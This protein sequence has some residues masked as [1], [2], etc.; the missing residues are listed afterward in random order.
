MSDTIQIPPAIAALTEE[1][2]AIRRDIHAHPEI[3]FEEV[4]TAGIV[5]AKLRSLGIEVH[6][7]VGKTGVVGVLTAG[8]GGNRR[9]GLRADMDALPLDEETGLEF[10]ST[11]PGK[12]H[13]CGH[14]VHTTILLGAAQYLAESRNFDGTVVFVFQPAEEGLGGARAMLADG[15]FERFPVDEIFG[16]H[17][18]SFQPHGFLHVSP[19]TSMAGADFFDI[20]IKGRGGHAAAPENSRDPLLAAAALTQALQQIISRNVAANDAAVVSVTELHAGSAYNIIADRAQLRG[21]VRALSDKV[22][23]AIGERIRAIAAGIALSHDVEIEVK[24]RDVF[25]TLTNSDEQLEAIAE[26]GRTVLGEANVSTEPRR[27]L[28]SEDFADFLKVVPGA[29]F[30]V[31]HHGTV[32]LHNPK[33]VV[34]EGIIPVGVTLF[35]RLVEARLPVVAR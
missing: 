23:A 6:E 27:V 13:G 31:G 34:D 32:P 11:I 22:R 19:G 5:A 1:L 7:G 18:S 28:G 17:N 30:T 35:G 21:T 9:I 16:L 29:F 2:V 33:F 12:F 4:R 20:E 14:D 3:G 8:A 10:A 26:V 15:V 25:S 24:L